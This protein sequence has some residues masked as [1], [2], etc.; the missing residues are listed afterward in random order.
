MATTLEAKE[1]ETRAWMRQ[2][3]MD[4]VGRLIL[5]TDADIED[6]PWDVVDA[7][8]PRTRP[9]TCC[10]CTLVCT[11][12]TLTLHYPIIIIIFQTSPT[13]PCG[14]PSTSPWPR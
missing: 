13:K 5:F 4:V 3:A 2:G 11:K 14:T 1:A 7:S 12:K 8:R 10:W 9:T 6:N